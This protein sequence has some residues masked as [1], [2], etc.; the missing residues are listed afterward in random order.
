M[1]IRTELFLAW[2]YLQPKRNA[3]SVITCISIIGVTLGVAVL[4][5]VL[6]VMTGFT[7]LM[8]EKLLETTSHIQIYD[9]FSDFIS[10]PKSAISEVEKAGATGMPVVYRPIL[11]QKN[12]RFVPKM[13]FGIDPAKVEKKFNISENISV[14]KFSLE[15][16]EVIVSDS[17]AG[18]LGLRIGDKVI[19]H[20]PNKLSKMIKVKEKGKIELNDKSEVYLPGEYTVTAFYS[21]GKYDFDKNVI[22]MNIDDSNELYGY[23]WGSASAV[24]V[25]TKDPFNIDPIMSKLK[26]TMIDKRIYSWKDL[27]QKLLGVL[28]VE[29]NMMFFLLVFIVLVAAFSITNTLITVVVQKT[30]EIGLLK[31]LGASSNGVMRIFI[32]QGLFVGVLGTCAG[33]FM[34]IM[35]I[36]W[37]NQ[38][39]RIMSKVSGMEIFPK[40]FYFFN[41]LPAHIVTSDL[42]LI[43][44]ISVFLCTIGGII[45]A[46]RAARLLPAKALKYE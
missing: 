15:K 34:G 3:V 26:E 24:F 13:V 7:D 18:E 31:A 40:E 5:V 9:K 17:I 44:V 32:F 21:F 33:T 41:E 25:W 38:I 27:N 8:K 20:A 6:A 43:G 28:A 10:K 12:D 39:L 11:A 1:N 35:V 30:R 42:V 16:N 37:R 22:F 23:P 46:W 14:G 19:L 4:I 45:P 2:R 29:K 36:V